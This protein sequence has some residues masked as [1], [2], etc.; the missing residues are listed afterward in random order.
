MAAI[1]RK[2]NQL[3]ELAAEASSAHINQLVPILSQSTFLTLKTVL[4]LRKKTVIKENNMLRPM[5]CR[6][7]ALKILKSR[8]TS[9]HMRGGKE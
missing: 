8:Q 5:K 2:F 3:C 7:C 4:K 6:N 1:F 9:W